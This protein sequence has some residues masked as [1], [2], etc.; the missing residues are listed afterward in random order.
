MW[1]I[2]TVECHSAIRKHERLPFV[3]TW[4]H[5]KTITLVKNIKQKKSRATYDF[6]PSWDI[7]LKAT[8]EQTRKTHKQLKDS[9]AVVT[10]EKEDG[11]R[12][13]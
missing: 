2:Y 3:T 4:I 12:I 11:S 10:R 9:I 1:Y 8:N 7:K 5:L 13:E 6:T